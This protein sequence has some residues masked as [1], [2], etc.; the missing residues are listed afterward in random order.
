MITVSKS[1]MKKFFLILALM[2]SVSNLWAQAKATNALQAKFDNSLALYF[3]K[4]TLRMLNQSENK[5]F[6][7]MVKN[8][9]KLKFLMVDKSTRNFGPKEYQKLVQDYRA[10]DYESAMTGR[11]Q[12]R[13]F[14][15]FIK[16]KPRSTVVLVNDSTSLF[17]LD[18]V[19][20]IDASKAGTLFSTIDNSTD[21]GKKIRNF[22]EHKGKKDW[23]REKDKEKSEH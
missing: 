12:G 16:D 17:V 20:T 10:E 5:D 14:D 23:D 19:G 6:D 15:V 8:I 1:S 3:Y 2:A 21:I 9:D 22:T 11:M 7:D 4:N 13:N 18:M